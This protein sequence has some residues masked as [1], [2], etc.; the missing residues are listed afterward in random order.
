MEL[1]ENQALALQKV[2]EGK[3]IFITG[4]GGSGKTELIRRIVANVSATKKVQVCALTGCAAILLQ[5]KAR[6]VHSFAGIGLANG[7][8]DEVVQ[9]ALSGRK[10]QWTG[11][12]I[13]IVDEVSMMSAK[14]F[15]ILDQI[16]RRARKRFDVPFGGLQLVFSGDFY[17][18]PPVEPNAC[19]CFESPNW[20]TTFDEVIVLTTIFRQ[21]DAD[22]RSILNEIRVGSLSDDACEILKQQLDKP[23]EASF[24]PTMICARRNDADRFNSAELCALPGECRL[25][26]LQKVRNTQPRSRSAHA[27]SAHSNSA[28]NQETNPTDDAKKRIYSEDQIDREF[29]NLTKAVIVDSEIS[30]KIGTQVM[31]TANLDVE[32]QIVNG[33]QGTVIGFV[34]GLPVV[35]FTNGSERK[36]EFHKWCSEAIPFIAVRQLPLIYAW[37]ITIHKAQGIS[38]DVAQ[39]D[40]G[41]SIVECGQIYVALSRVKSLDGLH[42]TDLN[43]S[44]IRA[45]PK[46]Q[47]YYALHASSVVSPRIRPCSFL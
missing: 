45:N 37:A 38:L 44:K 35:R 30:L 46:V 9:R 28:I 23:I 2:C 34:D 39:I 26:H 40:A 32:N 47:A 3:S 16:A 6:T 5:C 21:T 31:I 4:P 13:L 25:F 18:L 17:Q 12:D 15:T 11:T 7:T 33:S 43:P 27:S 10:Q 24:K 19:F 29:Q 8:E 42:L 22:Y 14:I 20:S 1:S 41:S 36:I